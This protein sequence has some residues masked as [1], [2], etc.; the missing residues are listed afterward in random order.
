MI[1]SDFIN[2]D[3]VKCRVCLKMFVLGHIH[4]LFFSVHSSCVTCADT[5]TKFIDSVDKIG[6]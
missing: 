5:V 3:C 1:I 6:E 2:L 4:L